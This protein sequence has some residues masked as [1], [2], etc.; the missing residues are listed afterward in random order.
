[1]DPRSEAISLA[2]VE[3]RRRDVVFDTSGGQVPSPTVSAVMVRAFPQVRRYQLVQEG[4][5][6][7]RVVLVQGSVVYLEVDV[8][9]ELSRWLGSDASIEVESVA[10]IPPLA[11]G[12]HRPVVCRDD[13]R[14][15]DTPRG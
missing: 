10:Q 5:A 15:E 13:P 2:S 8:A 9:A 1:V 12:K 7:Y 11:S 4:R 6:S 14:T 3:G